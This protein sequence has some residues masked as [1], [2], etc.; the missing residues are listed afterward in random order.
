M[1]DEPQIPGLSMPLIEHLRELRSRLLK[2]F[3]AVSVA[4]GAAWIYASKIFEFLEAPLA[5]VL[6]KGQVIYTSP[7]EVFM[8]NVKASILT[9]VFATS[10]FL[11]YQVWKFVM[12]GLYPR[13]R[14]YVVPFVIAATVFFLGGASFCYWVMFPVA[15]QF[16]IGT[17]Q[18]ATITAQIKVESYFAFATKMLLAF[19]A[20][21]ELP[22]VVLFLA[23]MGL[24]TPR[25]LLKNF[26]YAVLIL[27]LA[28]AVFTP[29]P[30][31]L[32]MMLLLGPLLI[33]YGLSIAA[34]AVFGKKK[35]P[36]ADAEPA[37]EPQPDPPAEG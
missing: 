13:E 31:V 3:V 21:F 28:A 5:R 19:G 18:T 6:G 36:E 11:F 10:P 12:P 20:S 34:A 16:F 8:T 27:A 26:R 4:A 33:L 23:R 14:R 37:A 32:S 17:F 25:F 22:L 2:C 9:A 29:T 1:A 24:V 15:L 30:D 35:E 7:A